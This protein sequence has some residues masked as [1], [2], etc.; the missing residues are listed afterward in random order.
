LKDPQKEL[1]DEI[2]KNYQPLQ[3]TLI[4]EHKLDQK[5]FFNI[6]LKMIFIKNK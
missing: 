2:K 4:Q 5:L 6:L 1:I 3:K